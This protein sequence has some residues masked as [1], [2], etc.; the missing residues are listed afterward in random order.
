[1]LIKVHSDVCLLSLSFIYIFYLFGGALVFDLLERSHEE[2][3]IS[4]LNNYIS[5]FRVDHASCIPTEDLN[6]FV[7]VISKANDEGIP[8]VNNFSKDQNWSFGQ[9]IFFAGTILTTIGYG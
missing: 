6:D 3:V 8:A 1:M 2:Q 4:N 5:Q 7:R 9:T